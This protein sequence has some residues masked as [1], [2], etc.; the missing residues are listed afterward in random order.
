MNIYHGLGIILASL[1]GGASTLAGLLQL[2]LKKLPLRLSIGMS[3]AG[4][5][6]ILS[7]FFIVSLNS[8]AWFFLMSGLLTIQM[9]AYQN[10]KY[11][12]GK[13][14]TI[15]HV[16]RFALSCFILLLLWIG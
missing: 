13:I 9:V 15:H 10:G 6:V 16:V 8:G 14:H 2:R 5:L 3:V 11:L 7:A 12:Y 1:Y 4:M